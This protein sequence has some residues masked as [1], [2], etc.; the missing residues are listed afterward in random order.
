MIPLYLALFAVSVLGRVGLIPPSVMEQTL[1]RLIG[2][3]DYPRAGSAR[4]DD[5]DD[6]R[7]LGL[8]VESDAAVRDAAYRNREDE[9]TEAL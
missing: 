1:K 5:G 2:I 3:P 4:G 6:R 8:M 9:R 7:P